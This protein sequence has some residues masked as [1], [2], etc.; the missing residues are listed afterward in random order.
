M[1]HSRR[2]RELAG[3]I[4]PGVEFELDEAITR[5]KKSANAKFDETIEIALNLGVDPRHSDQM[6]RSTVSLPHG[7]G[8]VVRVL[9]LCKE[10]RV[11]E[12]LDAGAD[13]AGLDEYIE[14]IKGGWTEVDSCL[15]TPDVMPQVGKIGRVLGPR[16]LMPNPKTGTVT[17]DISKTVKE[18]KEGRLS[19]RVDRYGIIHLPVGKASFEVAK[20]KENIKALILTLQRLRPSAAKGQYFRKISLTSTMGP[21]VR[22]SRASVLVSVR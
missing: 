6:I 10:D 17:N 13:Y 9:V 21:G 7:V 4:E 1:T 18:I 15:A 8:K 2:Y 12:A 5:V 20:L 11:E 14:K 16:G 19:F 3:G 22:V